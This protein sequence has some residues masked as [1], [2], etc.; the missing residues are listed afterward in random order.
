MSTVTLAG[1]SFGT[2]E[3][4]LSTLRA[5]AKRVRDTLRSSRFAIDVSNA[6]VSH[7]ASRDRRAQ[8]LAIGEYL[9]SRHFRFIADP[10]G[11]ELL[12]D[13]A[14]M[15]LQI[16]QRG[17]TQGDCDDA[18]MLAAVLGMAN[19]LP[20]RFRAL[21][22]GSVNA[23]YTHV[24]TDLCVGG[25]LWYPLDVTKPQR[26]LAPEPTRTLYVGV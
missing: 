19:G 23:P 13:P 22:F 14:E 3:S 2:N 1:W 16:Q 26:F 6:L 4:A 17:F 18:A 10:I 24:I 21:A 8:A 5:M 7:T 9:S 20:A 15:L 25:G 12:R 11:V